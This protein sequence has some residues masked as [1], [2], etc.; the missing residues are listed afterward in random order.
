MR[1]NLVGDRMI[2]AVDIGNSNIVLGCIDEKNIYFVARIAT[3]PLKSSDQYA[4][5]IKNIVELYGLSLSK[6]DG[7]IISS[8][9]PPLSNTVKESVRMITNKKTLVVAPGLKTG[10]NILM[11]NP[12]QLGSDLVVVSVAALSEYENS[13]II[14]DMGTATTMSV[15][16][17]NRN[18]IGGAII[19]GVKL[20]I[21]ALSSR[22]AQLPHISL[23]P[24]KKIIGKN[25]IECMTS[26]CICG[27]AAILDGMIERIEEELGYPTT[28]IATGGLS[29]FIVP[30]CKHKITYDENLLLKGLY[31]IYKK[32][33]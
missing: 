22:T 14:I 33:S 9:V 6:I 17:K 7:S 20:S 2:L 32:N 3:D 4:V 11:D 29:Q 15:I 10:L 8:V 27:N 28:V 21:D 5:E 19:P 23:E 12:A 30:L 26:G 1:K 16:D 18:Y 24:P 13:L 31:I 25:T